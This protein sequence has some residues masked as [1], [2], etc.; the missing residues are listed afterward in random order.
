MTRSG[1][2]VVVVFRDTMLRRSIVASDCLP[3]AIRSW[4]GIDGGRNLVQQPGVC[5]VGFRNWLRGVGVR[6]PCIRL[7]RTNLRVRAWI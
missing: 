3:G 1:D 7:C 4:G 5:S 6:V 2:S